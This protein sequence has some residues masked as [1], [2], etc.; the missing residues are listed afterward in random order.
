MSEIRFYHLERQNI[1]QA[2]PALVSKAYDN[3]HRIIIKANDEK[4]LQ[5]INDLLWTFHPNSFLPHGSN[6]EGFEEDQPI[7]LTCDNDNPN[8]ADVLILTDGADHEK[9]TEFALICEMF[10]GRDQSA[11]QSA[12]T[13]WKKYKDQNFDLTYWQQTERGWE[14]KET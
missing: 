12:R 2:L 7:F 1:D 14:K 9:L 4:Q 8:S 13:R 10:D 6:K 3:G 5:R 11:L